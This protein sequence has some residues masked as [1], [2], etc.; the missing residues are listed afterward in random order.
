MAGF[1]LDRVTIWSHPS[2]SLLAAEYQN[3]SGPGHILVRF[4]DLIETVE[5]APHSGFNFRG[6]DDQSR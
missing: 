4:L 3:R 1:P 2:L 5:A 6:Y